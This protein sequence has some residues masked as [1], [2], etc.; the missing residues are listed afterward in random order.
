[1]IIVLVGT[2]LSG[3]HLRVPFLQAIALWALVA[4][5]TVTVLQRFTTVYRQSKAAEMTRAEAP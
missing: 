4:A 1:L 5:S 2:G 3:E